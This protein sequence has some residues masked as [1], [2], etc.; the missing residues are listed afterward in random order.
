MY[1]CVCVVYLGIAR[2]NKPI[3]ESCMEIRRSS[4]SQKDKFPNYTW[5]V[6]YAAAR[7]NARVPYQ[8][9]ICGRFFQNFPPWYELE[10]LLKL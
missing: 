1:M 8:P 2:V 6:V 9:S 7:A 3:R 4:T 5:N 10:G